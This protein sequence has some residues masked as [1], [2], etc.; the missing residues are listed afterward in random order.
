VDQARDEPLKELAL[1]EDDLRLVADSD[2]HIVISLGW[3]AEPDE[4]DQDLGA[5]TEQEA[6]NREGRR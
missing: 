6:A 2:S 4:I 5:A 3:L 1:A